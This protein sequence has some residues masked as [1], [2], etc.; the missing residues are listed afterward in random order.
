MGLTRHISCLNKSWLNRPSPTAYVPLLK[1]LPCTEA[2]SV[3]IFKR[4]S[5]RNPSGAAS[6]ERREGGAYTYFDDL[7]NNYFVTVIVIS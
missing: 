7:K 5:V 3:K 2:R 1:K 4:V 6:T